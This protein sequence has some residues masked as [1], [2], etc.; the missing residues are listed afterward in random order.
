MGSLGVTVIKGS[1]VAAFEN[2]KNVI[3]RV[4]TKSSGLALSASFGGVN[5]ALIN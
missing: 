1:G 4:K 2:S 5:I 3:L